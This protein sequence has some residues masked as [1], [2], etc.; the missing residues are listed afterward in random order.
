MSV[1]GQQKVKN[2]ANSVHAHTEDN[3]R[4]KD[5]NEPRV[6]IRAVAVVE[7]ER[8]K[9]VQDSQKLAKSINLKS[10]NLS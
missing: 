2:G 1:V 7:P 8:P 6:K 10:D 4:E 5:T 9:E 3:R